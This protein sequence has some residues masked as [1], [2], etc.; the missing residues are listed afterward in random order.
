MKPTYFTLAA[1]A[2]AP[3]FAQVLTGNDLLQRITSDNPGMKSI[4]LGYVGG[5]TDSLGGDIFC[6][7]EGVTLAQAVDMVRKWL[8]D[9]PEHR[10]MSA[11]VLVAVILQRA[12]PCRRTPTPG[13]KPE[14]QPSDSLR[15]GRTL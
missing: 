12:W 2:A 8:S 10:H 1:L 4:A 3:S 13:S 15:P 6:P 9:N 14:P 11:A 7:P 5:V